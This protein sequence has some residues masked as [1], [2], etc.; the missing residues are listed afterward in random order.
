MGLNKVFDEHYMAELVFQYYAGYDS[1]STTAT[2]D[3][4]PFLYSVTFRL[5]YRF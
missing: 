1:A 3:Y 5:G 4:I 2:A